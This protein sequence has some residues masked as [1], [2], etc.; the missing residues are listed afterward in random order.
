V[1][2]QERLDVIRQ[3]HQHVAS[4]YT[5]LLSVVSPEQEARLTRIVERLEDFLEYQ[6]SERLEERL[7]K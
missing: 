1:T 7:M 6:V 5:L 4:A 2:A 3:A